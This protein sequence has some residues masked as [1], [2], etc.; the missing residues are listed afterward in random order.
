MKE[1]NGGG[2]GVTMGV[3]NHKIN[4]E[5]HLFQIKKQRQLSDL[6][7]LIMSVSKTIEVGQN[8]LAEQGLTLNLIK[9]ARL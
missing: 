4:K 6:R 2:G 5:K 1:R 9:R 3:L 7:L 8:I